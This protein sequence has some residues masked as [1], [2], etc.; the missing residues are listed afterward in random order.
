MS[1]GDFLTKSWFTIILYYQGNKSGV[2]G[3]SGELKYS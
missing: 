1:L 3:L 2:S